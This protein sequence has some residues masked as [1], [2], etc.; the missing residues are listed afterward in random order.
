MPDLST[1]KSGQVL[2]RTPNDGIP[3]FCPLRCRRQTAETHASTDEGCI[4]I[5][6]LP[7]KRTGFGPHFCR[8]PVPDYHAADEIIHLYAV[9]FACFHSYL[10][11]QAQLSRWMTLRFSIDRRNPGPITLSGELPWRSTFW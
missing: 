8:D 2:V 7:K 1:A 6:S 4:R 5:R 9:L 11:K 10:S 3:G